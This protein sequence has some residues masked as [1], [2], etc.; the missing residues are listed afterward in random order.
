[1]PELQPDQPPPPDYY[2]E[3]VRRLLSHVL[4]CHADLLRSGEVDYARTL[5]AASADAQ[6]LFARLITRKGPWI[7]QDKLVYAEVGCLHAAVRELQQSGIITCNAAA[8]ADF[9]LRLL[10][11]GERRKLFPRVLTRGRENW[12]TECVSRYPDEYIRRVL[13]RRHS[14]LSL[15]RSGRFAICQLLFFGDVHQDTS[16]FV[17]QDLGLIRYPEYALKRSDRMFAIKSELE[18]YRRLGRLR[19]LSHRLSEHAGL[20]QSLSAALWQ[21]PASRHE[22]R[23][24]DAVLNRL[25]AHFERSGRFDD[26]LSC[27]ARSRSHPARERRVRILNRLADT[28]GCS[29][30]LEAMRENPVAAEEEDFARYFGRRRRT[31]TQTTV[32]S[33]DGR[34]PDNI[35]AHAAMLLSDAGGEAWHLENQLPRMLAGLAYWEVIF[36]PLRGAFVNPFQSGPVDL[37]WPD[38]AAVRQKLLEQQDHAIAPAGSFQACLLANYDRYEGLA[39]RLVSWRS[40][41]R[42]RLEL[43]LQHVPEAHL[44]DIAQHLIRQPYR[45]RNGFPD[46]LVIYGAGSYEFVEVKGPTDSLQPAQR[47]WLRTLDAIGAPARVLKFKS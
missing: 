8:P 18:S 29:K 44:R 38:F 9:L 19:A 32:L 33:L 43:L 6:R 27:Y 2:A 21:P 20:A 7:R 14:W 47:V 41:S 28:R 35:E 11:D 15:H 13:V 3:N 12:I 40:W 26:A 45:A 42:Q 39:N 16:T 5:L 4:D 23:Q 24:R 46:L 1:M 17:L 25:G 34:R 31:P 30:L 22:Q 37:F 36:A 10:V